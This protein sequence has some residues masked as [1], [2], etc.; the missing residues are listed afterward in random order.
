MTIRS[1]HN[2]QR[3]HRLNGSHHGNSDQAL[4][5]TLFVA[6]PVHSTEYSAAR[7][8]LG[9]PPIYGVPCSESFMLA[10]RRDAL[11]RSGMAWQP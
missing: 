7:R 5:A 2:K 11:F 3:D 4:S 10:E 6:H 1:G 8:C 9:C